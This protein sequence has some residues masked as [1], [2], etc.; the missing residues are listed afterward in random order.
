MTI[1]TPES[2]EG[3]RL[4]VAFV[5]IGAHSA[6]AKLQS[7]A[8]TALQDHFSGFLGVIEHVVAAADLLDKRWNDL[9]AIDQTPPVVFPYEIAEVFGEQFMSALAIDRSTAAITIVDNILPFP[10]PEPV[11]AVV[12]CG[13][14]S[15]GTGA[16]YG[17][18]ESLSAA[19]EWAEKNIRDT[20]FFTQE[21]SPA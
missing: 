2:C 17:P 8:R 21:M 19:D 14:L 7:A 3:E 6:W 16:V 5:A 13:S 10:A 4:T 15:S 1:S 20:D 12:V 18:F 11:P 9:E